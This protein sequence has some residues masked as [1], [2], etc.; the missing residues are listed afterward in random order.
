MNT[1]TQ[2][3][4]P[5]RTQQPIGGIQKPRPLSQLLAN[6]NTKNVISLNTETSGIQ[7]DTVDSESVAD[8]GISATQRRLRNRITIARK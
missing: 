3:I 2:F 8:T 5:P 6:T 7:V 1:Q 4:A